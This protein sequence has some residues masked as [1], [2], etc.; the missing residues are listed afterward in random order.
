MS[1]KD[2]PT[3]D[4][5]SKDSDTDGSGNSEGHGRQ[6]GK[7]RIIAF[8]VAGAAL[9]AVALLVAYL[10]G[11]FHQHVWN[12]PTCTEPKTCSECGAIDG[13]PLGH[14]YK[15]VHKDADCSHGAKRCIRV[16]GAETPTMN[17]MAV[18]RWVMI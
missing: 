6:S 16:R 13:E 15:S 10:A 3:V 7:Q 8:S 2:E 12:D 18:R 4:V 1:V 17:L 11:A 9:V 5:P 14:D